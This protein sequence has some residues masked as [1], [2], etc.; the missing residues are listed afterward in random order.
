M[1]SRK[2]FADG[3]LL[4]IIAMVAMT[5]DHVGFALGSSYYGQSQA[6]DILVSVF[7]GIG[8]IALPLFCFLIVE[9]VLH[10]KNIKNYLLRLGIMSLVIMA[11]IITSESIPY[12]K[13]EVFA[14]GSMGNIFIDLL[15]GALAVY[16]LKQK[17]QT[18]KLFAAL[19][20]IFG[21]LSFIAIYLEQQDPNLTVWWMPYFLRT[22]SGFHVILLCMG[23]YSA[24]LLKDLWLKSND[25]NTSAIYEEGTQA[26]FLV[27]LIS[28]FILIVITGLLF[29]LIRFILATTAFVDPSFGIFSGALILFYNGKR[30]YNKNWFKYGCYLY[31]PLHLLVIFGVFMIISLV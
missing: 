24:Y 4:K 30:G 6:I 29:I 26:R 27:N 16:L 28:I 31:Y 25:V 7:R 10:T 2:L 1:D 19:P 9:G 23:F 3:F 17:N 13:N 20:L 12:I 5:F 8:Q 14:L 21:V 15:L 18:L 22:Q 11:A